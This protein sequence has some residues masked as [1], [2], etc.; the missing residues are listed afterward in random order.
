MTNDRKHITF[1]ARYICCTLVCDCYNMQYG[2]QC[3]SLY[4]F[5]F[6]SIIN[7]RNIFNVKCQQAN[8]QTFYACLFSHVEPCRV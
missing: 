8:K 6:C 4:Y 7:C 2:K 3:N 1:T 5:P